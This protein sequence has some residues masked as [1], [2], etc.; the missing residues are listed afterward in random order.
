MNLRGGFCRSAPARKT[1]D[2]MLNPQNGSAVV[3]SIS[4]RVIA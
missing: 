2:P 1:V 4:P 3:A